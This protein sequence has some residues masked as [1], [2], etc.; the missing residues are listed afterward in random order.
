MEIAAL[1]FLRTLPFGRIVGFLPIRCGHIP[2]AAPQGIIPVKIFIQAFPGHTDQLDQDVHQHSLQFV[3]AQDK[4][5]PLYCVMRR[6]PLDN[7]RYFFKVM[8]PRE[9]KAGHTTMLLDTVPASSSESSGK[10]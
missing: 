2:D 4:K 3:R 8:T 1:F 6:P 7:S 10:C 9:L 5:D